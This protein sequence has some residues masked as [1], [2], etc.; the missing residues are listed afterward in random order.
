MMKQAPAAVQ[1]VVKPN[2]FNDYYIKCV[3]KHVTIKLNGLTTVDDDFPKM[4]DDGLIAWQLHNGF[5][6]MEVTF[7]DI[8]FKDLS[9]KK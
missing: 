2:D 9:E 3:G 7:K 4:P 6:Y 1:K 5:K 8:E